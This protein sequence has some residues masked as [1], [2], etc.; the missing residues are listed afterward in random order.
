MNVVWTIIMLSSIIALIFVNP[1]AAATS[2]TKGAN[3]AVSLSFALLASYSLWLGLFTLVEKTGLSEKL[4]KALRPAIGFL[5]P[6]TN[7]RTRK[8]ISMNVAA[9]FLGLGNAATP[10]GI[11]AV[12]SMYDGNKK[13]NSNMIMFLVLSSA[14]VQ[15]LPSTVIAMRISRDSARPTEFLPACAIA[16]V[17]SALTGIALV[18]IYDLFKKKKSTVRKRSKI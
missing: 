2:M 11:A 16:T 9:N 8:F 7:D 18:K 6:G 12:S 5:F 17:F 10:M 1:N 4:S 3:D 14:S 13:A 15:L